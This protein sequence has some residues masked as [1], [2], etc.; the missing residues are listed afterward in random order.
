MSWK[1]TVWEQRQ[2]ERYKNAQDVD[3]ALDWAEQG[4]DIGSG[5]ASKFKNPLNISG[6]IEKFKN[7]L[8]Y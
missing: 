4:W 1:D 8:F 7:S 2:I 6:S 5:L 3:K